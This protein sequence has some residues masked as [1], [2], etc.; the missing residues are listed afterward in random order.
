[1][2]TLLSVFGF[3]LTS[4]YLEHSH[5]FI[6][7]ILEVLPAFVF[8]FQEQIFLLFMYLVNQRFSLFIKSIASLFIT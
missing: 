2:P 3:P 4:K 7:L 1:M 6:L 8:Q 5:N